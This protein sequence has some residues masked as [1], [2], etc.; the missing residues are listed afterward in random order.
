MNHSDKEIFNLIDNNYLNSQNEILCAA[1]LKNSLFSPQEYLMINSFCN[2][3]CTILSKKEK[4]NFILSKNSPNDDK[5]GFIKFMNGKFNINKYIT[6]NI[7]NI[8]KEIYNDS[9]WNGVLFFVPK[10]NIINKIGIELFY[11]KYL[12]Q[13]IN[14]P[15]KKPI[16]GDFNI[17]QT[18]SIISNPY[19]PLMLELYH[20]ILVV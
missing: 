10:S 2:K 8:R 11:N 15:F 6:E 13:S 3:N 20:K 14:Y 5:D 4:L 16:I 19:K 1:Y 18:D 7:L 12:D 9:M 17:F